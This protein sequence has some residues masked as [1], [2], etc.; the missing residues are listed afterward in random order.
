[1]SYTNEDDETYPTWEDHYN[2]DEINE[3]REEYLRAK[4]Y[5]EAKGYVDHE[6]ESILAY[7]E[8]LRDRD[9]YKN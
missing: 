1:M 5:Q 6:R 9:K 8:Y 7:A 3:M 4:A 2:A